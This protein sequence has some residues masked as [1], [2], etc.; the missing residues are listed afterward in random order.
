MAKNSSCG[1]EL[2]TKVREERRVRRKITCLTLVML[3]IEIKKKGRQHLG[4]HCKHTLKARQELH[5]YDFGLHSL[6]AGVSAFSTLMELHLMKPFSF[7]TQ[8]FTPVGT[9]LF[10]TVFHL[11]SFGGGGI[12]ALSI[13]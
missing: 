7:E 1:C 4:H 13:I 5:C 12:K 9:L 3:R 11:M 8:E 6:D 2:E 10:F